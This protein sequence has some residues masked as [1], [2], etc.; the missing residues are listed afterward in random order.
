MRFPAKITPSCIWVAI[1]LLIELFYIGLPVVRTDGRAGECTVTWLPNFLGWVDYF[2]F[3]PVVLRAR[4][5]RYYPFGIPLILVSARFGYPPNLSFL[6]FQKPRYVPVFWCHTNLRVS[7]FGC[8]PDLSIPI[9]WTPALKSV[10]M[11]V[12]TL[13]LS[14]SVYNHWNR[15]YN[16]TSL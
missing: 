14:W 15:L 5:L 2:I 8:F 16:L 10:V 11:W 4:E 9:F 7:H 6:P 12:K 1:D 13:I 3:L